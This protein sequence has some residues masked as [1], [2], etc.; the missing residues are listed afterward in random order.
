MVRGANPVVAGVIIDPDSVESPGMGGGA[1][2]GT[3]PSVSTAGH[4]SNAG[5]APHAG[6]SLQG[7]G[8][9]HGG[10]QVGNNSNASGGYHT[11]TAED[12]DSILA[13]FRKWD[14]KGDDHISEAELRQVLSSL[15]LDKQKIHLLFQ[16]IDTNKNGK[17]C[18]KE[19]VNWLYGAE[20]NAI[21]REAFN[22][23]KSNALASSYKVLIQRLTFELVDAPAYSGW[24]S[25]SNSIRPYVRCC[26]CALDTLR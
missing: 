15:G 12:R 3:R 5:G 7:G 11:A 17:I 18:Y 4:Y 6:G 23:I 9:L 1:S 24:F 19:F 2:G 16:E 10:G 13:V 22:Q 14:L 8:A 20:S 25:D 26:K 21:G